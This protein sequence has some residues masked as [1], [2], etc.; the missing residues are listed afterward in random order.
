MP[1]DANELDLTEGASCKEV[2]YDEPF[3]ALDVEL[4]EDRVVG[5]Q[6]AAQGGSEVHRLHAHSLR[7]SEAAHALVRER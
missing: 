1:L 4:D 6:S 3:N 2:R 7:C 5:R